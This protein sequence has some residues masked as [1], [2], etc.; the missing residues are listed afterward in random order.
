MQLAA[1]ETDRSFQG[2]RSPRLEQPARDH[3]D[4]RT[5]AAEPA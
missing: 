5:I 3:V 4:A 1:R 2:A